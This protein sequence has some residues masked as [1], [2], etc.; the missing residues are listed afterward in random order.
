MEEE[1]GLHFLPEEVIKIASNKPRG[2]RVRASKEPRMKPRQQP[3]L[4]MQR[5]TVMGKEMR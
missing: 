4:S 2:P 5:K 1:G 3:R